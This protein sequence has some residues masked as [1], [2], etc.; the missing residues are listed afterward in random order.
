MIVDSAL[1]IKKV[2]K[3]IFEKK[4]L[5]VMALDVRGI[6]NI[7]DFFIIAE[8][9]AD[10]H[11]QAIAQAIVDEMSLI[12]IK[13]QHIEGKDIGEWIV[14]DFFD[15]IV[16]LFKPG[17]RDYYRIEELWK[18]APIVPLELKVET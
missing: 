8:G 4:G 9:S 12:G 14:L 10:R 7:T 15:F 18:T 5:N 17:I 6:C 3:I 13:P 1:I 2:A 16:H 11:V